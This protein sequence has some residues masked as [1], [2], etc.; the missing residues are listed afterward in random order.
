[1]L[2][3]LTLKRPSQRWYGDDIGKFASKAISDDSGGFFDSFD[4]NIAKPDYAFSEE[5]TCMSGITKY[6]AVGEI[7][8]VGKVTGKVKFRAAMYGEL[9]PKFGFRQSYVYVRW[10]IK[11][12]F[13]L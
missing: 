7:N 11:G 13:A 2:S 1:M 5:I 4:F 10:V 6:K 9:W 3:A 8:A 12:D